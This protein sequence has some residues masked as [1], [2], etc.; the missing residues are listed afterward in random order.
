[1]STDLITYLNYMSTWDT[2]SDENIDKL[3]DEQTLFVGLGDFDSD[4]AVESEF[5]TLIDLADQVRD[6]TIAADAIQIAADA[7][8]VA[9]IW[10]FGLSMAAFAALEAA[11]AIDKKFISSKSNDLNAKLKT[12][13]IDISAL[14]NPNVNSY[15]LK[16][17]DNNNL[18]AS[19]A[20][21]GLD[22]RTCRSLLMQFLVQVQKKEGK[23]D[24]VSFRKYAESAR[25]LF[26]GTEINAV[27]NAYD[28]LNLSNKTDADIQTFLGFLKG[29]DFD[30]TALTIIYGFS[31][32]FMYTK[33]GIA[34]KTIKENAKAAG[35]D[36]DEVESSSFG[37][38]DAVGKFVT[39]VAVVMSVVDAVLDIIDIVDVVEQ[40]EKMVDQLNGPIKESYKTYFDGI[41][42][43][44]KDYNA[45]IAPTATS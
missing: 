1:M 8:A 41:K 11:E 37:M 6:L 34:N 35:F 22:T 38:M 33:L 30:R 40:T 26:N 14:I 44:S 2:E 36:V 23:L 3:I 43:A 29:L 39:V 42:T 7:A 9:A 4:D 17:K 19:K 45:A 5:K 24:A 25:I 15:I 27:Y 32:A 21:T 16:Y 31:I 13:D 20:P 10:S 18:I 12:V 28:T